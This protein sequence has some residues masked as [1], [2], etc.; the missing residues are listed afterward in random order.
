MCAGI[1]SALGSSYA[2]SKL[3]RKR[4]QLEMSKRTIMGK[5]TKRVILPD[6]SDT[7]TKKRHIQSLIPK[8][9]NPFYLWNSK[10]DLDDNHTS[11]YPWNW[12]FLMLFMKSHG[13][14]WAL[15]ITSFFILKHCLSQKNIV[16]FLIIMKMP[17]YYSVLMM[18]KYPWMSC[19]CPTALLHS[20]ANC[21]S[22]A[23]A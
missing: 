17:C 8:A 9:S 21:N 11:N 13:A 5:K 19:S 2:S 3:S 4:S 1:C 12:D 20:P 10:V 7:T 6:Y 15:L 23:V 16:I 14:Y 22:V 18:I